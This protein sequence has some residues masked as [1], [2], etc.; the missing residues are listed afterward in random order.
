MENIYIYISRHQQ[1][2]GTVEITAQNAANFANAIDFIHPEIYYTPNL[3][4]RLILAS[5]KHF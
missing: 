5:T 2:Q 4:S 3:T 1:V